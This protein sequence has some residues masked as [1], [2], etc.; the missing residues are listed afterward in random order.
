MGVSRIAVTAAV[1]A[2]PVCATEPLTDAWLLLAALRKRDREDVRE[3]VVDA[4][5]IGHAR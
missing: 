2:N 5:G 1:L 3:H 4:Y